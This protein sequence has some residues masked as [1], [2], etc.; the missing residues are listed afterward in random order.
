VS[1]A[2][3][4]FSHVLALLLLLLHF[5]CWFFFVSLC[6][7]FPGYSE[8]ISSY[9]NR[10]IGTKGHDGAY[11]YLMSY[12]SNPSLSASEATTQLTAVLQPVI[13][14]ADELGQPCYMEV[15]NPKDVPFFES[16]GFQKN[17]GYTLFGCPVAILIRP[18][19]VTA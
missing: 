11:F 19:K 16:L 18:A 14:R 15:T 9:R 2:L 4:V 12:A 7:R 3:L 13:R 17:G 6:S 1:W 8:V 10:I 5:S